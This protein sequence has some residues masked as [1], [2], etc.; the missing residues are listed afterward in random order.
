MQIRWY[1][2]GHPGIKVSDLPPGVWP[3]SHS[4]G[5]L[6]EPGGGA[7][8]GESTDQVTSVVRGKVVYRVPK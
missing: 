7:P 2:G 4:H 1:R 3:I 6:R 5:R 8:P